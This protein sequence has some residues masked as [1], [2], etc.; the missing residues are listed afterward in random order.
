MIERELSREGQVFWVHN[1]VQGLERVVEFV[2]ELAPNARIGM[3]HGQL[4]EKKLEET[5]HAFWQWRIGYSGLY[6]YC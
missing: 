4:P 1:R 6:R 5:M 2:K 3:A